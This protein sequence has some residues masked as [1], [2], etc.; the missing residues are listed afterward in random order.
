M[1][2]NSLKQVRTI[3]EQTPKFN[4][5][6]Y[7]LLTYSSPP[8]SS[9]SNKWNKLY[10][11]NSPDKSINLATLSLDDNNSTP[12][13][14]ISTIRNRYSRKPSPCK[15]FVS[16]HSRGRYSL[17]ERNQVDDDGDHWCMIRHYF[18]ESKHL[19]LNNQTYF[20]CDK[21]CPSSFCRIFIDE[22]G[23][24]YSYL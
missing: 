5:P 4:T 15:L 8:H 22:N 6:S 12:I 21:N 24:K 9:D 17:V 7:P 1:N 10:Q 13:V 14:D 18:V 16:H 3:H 19:Q 23:N 20:D 11:Y 2:R